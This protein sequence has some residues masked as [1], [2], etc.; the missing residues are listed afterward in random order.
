MQHKGPPDANRNHHAKGQGPQ[1]GRQRGMKH[2][3]REE[4]NFGQHR[5]MPPQFQG[6]QHPRFQPPQQARRFKHS[7]HG[8]G[9][10]GQSSMR[11]GPSPQ[12]PM[13]NHQDR[14]SGREA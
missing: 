3:Q 2:R 14:R 12:A 8:R 13:P 4:Q 5:P 11:Q 1:H 7:R 10:Q 9:P 6:Q